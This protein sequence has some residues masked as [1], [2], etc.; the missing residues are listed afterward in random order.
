[1]GDYLGKQL[2]GYSARRYPHFEFTNY[3]TYIKYTNHICTKLTWCFFK[4]LFP[5][6]CNNSCLDGAPLLTAF[7]P[8]VLSKRM[9]SLQ[10]DHFS[11][12]VSS[13]HSCCLFLFCF[14]E[15]GE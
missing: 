8:K 2:L 6:K 9:F 15:A 4:I 3:I 13:A 14:F 1:M 10:Q 11:A 12:K 7:V 5:K